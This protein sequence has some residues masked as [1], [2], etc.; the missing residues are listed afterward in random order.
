[1][2]I[3]KGPDVHGILRTKRILNYT[4][5]NYDGKVIFIGKILLRNFKY[6]ISQI[7]VFL[8]ELN[9][10]VKLLFYYKLHFIYSM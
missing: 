4:G 6:Y 3:E 9:L 8:T 2:R 7:F 1:M 10:T 5:E